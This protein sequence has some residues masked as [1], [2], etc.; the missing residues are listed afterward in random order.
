M[1]I[2]EVTA[3]IVDSA[4]QIHTEIGPGLLESVYVLVLADRLASQGSW[5]NDRFHFDT[6][7]RQDLR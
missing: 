7:R 5:F 2:N 4:Y 3:A 6:D 1:E